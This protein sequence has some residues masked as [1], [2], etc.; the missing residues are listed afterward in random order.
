M[1]LSIS[2]LANTAEFK[3]DIWKYLAMA[4]RDLGEAREVNGSVGLPPCNNQMNKGDCILK[5]VAEILQDQSR[6]PRAVF[7]LTRSYR[8]CFWAMDKL[9][10]GVRAE[11]VLA[12]CRNLCLRDIRDRKIF[13]E[14]FLFE[15]L[16]KKRSEARE[17]LKQ[18]QNSFPAESI[19]GLEILLA[20]SLKD[21][22]ALTMLVRNI[23]VG[24]AAIQRKHISFLEQ[25]LVREPK[26]STALKKRAEA[27]ILEARDLIASF[28]KDK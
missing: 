19:L 18:I 8:T 7:A 5:Q 17:F 21:Q 2:S 26:T 24:L 13:A 11:I 6:E 16:S 9:G 23:G 20:D 4:N 25:S 14:S 1:S 15:S 3:E 27:A 28:L 10:E 22:K 12:E